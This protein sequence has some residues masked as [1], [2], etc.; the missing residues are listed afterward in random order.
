MT[1][2]TPVGPD[3]RTGMT[4]FAAASRGILPIPSR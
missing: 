3:T 2:P 1:S 4:K